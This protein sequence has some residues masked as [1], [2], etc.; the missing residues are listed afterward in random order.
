MSPASNPLARLVE[1]IGTLRALVVTTLPDCLP[2][3]SWLRRDAGLTP[4]EAAVFLGDL[5]RMNRQGLDA[6]GSE[7]RDLQLT[8]E[9]A[10]NLVVVRELSPLFVCSFLF[11]PGTSLGLV[12]HHVS[13]VCAQLAASLPAA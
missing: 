3:S 10:G 11:D 1:G 9:S 6:L 13:R 8:V 12:R 5:V 2:F 7:N 4:E